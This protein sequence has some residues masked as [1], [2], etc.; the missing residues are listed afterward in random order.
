MLDK[1]SDN[2][3]S[4]SR[5]LML[6]LKDM[7]QRSRQH[8]GDLPDQ[9]EAHWLWE[10]ILFYVTGSPVLASLKEIKEILNFPSA[11]TII[12]GTRKWVL[13]IANIRGNLLPV[14]DLQGFLGGKAL[15]PGKRSRVLV[16][17]HNGIRAGLLVGDIKGIR[18]FSEEQRMGLKDSSGPLQDFIVDAFQSDERTL[19][20]FSMAKLTESAEFQTASL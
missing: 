8:A 16:I 4:V 11:L 9:E 12:P 10:G 3:S 17:E 19:P 14:I 20:V 13:G 2:S 6:L 7:E 18:H 15:V 1:E 5:E